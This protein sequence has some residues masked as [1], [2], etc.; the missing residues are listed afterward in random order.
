MT[1]DS[2]NNNLESEAEE[3]LR[4]NITVKYQEK[5]SN[6]KKYIYQID[7]LFIDIAR[8][9][10]SKEILKNL[11]SLANLLKVKSKIKNIFKNKFISTTESKKVSYLYN[12]NSG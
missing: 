5:N 2:I 7:G 3:I 9:F 12:R 1:R 4:Q 8:N 6:N 10:I 11:F